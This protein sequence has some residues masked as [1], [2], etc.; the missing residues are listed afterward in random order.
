[1]AQDPEAANDNGSNL[2]KTSKTKL[3]D[4]TEIPILGFGTFIPARTRKHLQNSGN[5]NADNKDN[6]EDTL[7]VDAIA[8]ALKN[9]YIHID[10]A[11]V[12]D[13]ERLLMEGIEKGGK[14]RENIFITSKLSSRCRDPN[15]ARKNIEKSCEQLGGYIDLFLMHSPMTNNKGKDVLECYQVMMD[16]AKQ[17]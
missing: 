13:T 15:E 2:T 14:K 4:G 10:S 11:Q 17:G 1:M 9:G 16:L 12:Y 8:C 3:N 5:D 7:I 6:E